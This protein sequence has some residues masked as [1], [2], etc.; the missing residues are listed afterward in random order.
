MRTSPRT[1]S[2]IILKFLRIGG[3][4]AT[5]DPIWGRGRG[6]PNISLRIYRSSRSGGYP[7]QSSR[8]RG[9]GGLESLHRGLEGLVAELRNLFVDLYRQLLGHGLAAS[10]AA[11]VRALKGGEA[12]RVAREAPLP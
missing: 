9:R 2:T 10:G 12:E 11:A 7:V 1:R 4:R 3:E 6:W 5:N 8:G